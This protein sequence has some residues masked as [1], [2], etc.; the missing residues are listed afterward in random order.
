MSVIQRA[1]SSY[2]VMLSF[3]LLLCCAVA[4]G[5]LWSEQNR[6]DRWV[7]HTVEVQ[8][9]L[10][11]ARIFSLRADVERRGFLLTGSSKDRIA[12]QIDIASTRRTLSALGAMTLDNPRQQANVAALREAM[13]QRFAGMQRTMLLALQGR[14]RKSV[15]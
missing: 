11:S 8:S 3:G 7:R 12:A 10:A 1:R 6:S 5:W 4:A 2:L 13:D 9:R 15:V 14:D